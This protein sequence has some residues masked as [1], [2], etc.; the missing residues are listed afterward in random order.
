[1]TAYSGKFLLRLPESLHAR[2]AAQATQ[3]G[4]SLNAYCLRLL[5]EPPGRGRSMPAW[6]RVVER[7]M[8]ALKRRF[9]RGLIG[10]A[11]FGSQVRDEA[12]A[13]SDVDL[14]VVLS[15]KIPIVRSLYRWWE[16]VE[17]K[18]SSS[19]EINPHFVHLPKDPSQA[20][21]IWLETALHH[22]RIYASGTA[23]EKLLKNLAERIESGKIYRKWSNGH[24]YWVRSEH[25]E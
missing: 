25:E 18:T 14:L 12:T 21:G 16:E 24:P 20:G 8:P 3:A 9:G 13:K 5:S 10:V 11:A 23:L 22:E 6:R 15:E 17:A 2:L 4:L 19:F 1:M 7:R